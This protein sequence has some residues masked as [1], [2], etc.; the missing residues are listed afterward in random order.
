MAS[1]TQSADQR[2]KGYTP[3]KGRP[4][5]K[6]NDVERARGIR[7]D[8][9]TPPLTA[10]EAR[11]QRKA[12][13][14]SMSKEEYKEL[15]RKEREERAARSRAIQEG[16]DRGDERYLLDR[17]KGEVRAFV[18]DWVD[19]RRF[20]SNL[21][22]PVALVLLV[23]MFIAQ[24]NPEFASISSI[25]AMIVLGTFFIEGY[26]VGSRVNKAV[27]EKFPG[28]SETGFALGFYGYSRAS[29]LRKLRSP[30]PRV[31]IGADV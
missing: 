2:G 17:D 10:K 4:T 6:R 20:L 27:S 24:S 23:V 3:K 8:P 14:A 29:Q 16:I 26:L 7:R 11:A 30:R 5:P 21:V 22:M 15:K 13:K 9:V 1:D 19:A 18:R 25:I 31:E 28:T 12:L